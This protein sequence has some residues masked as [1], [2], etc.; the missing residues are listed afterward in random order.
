VL[1]QPQDIGR[2]IR[3]DACFETGFSRSD[4]GRARLIFLCR[5]W[6]QPRMVHVR[7]ALGFTDLPRL[8][9]PGDHYHTLARKT[10]QVF[11]ARGASHP[12]TSAIRALSNLHTPPM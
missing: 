7:L 2:L 1:C 8:L 9:G 5:V 4:L 6:L 10:K 11:T 12:G 3:T